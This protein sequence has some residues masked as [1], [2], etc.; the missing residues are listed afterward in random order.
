VSQGTK[1]ACKSSRHGT[2]PGSTDGG[3]FGDFSIWADFGVSFVA[4]DSVTQNPGNLVPA[5]ASS[6]LDAYPVVFG[7]CA[8]WLVVVFLGVAV[9]FVARARRKGAPRVLDF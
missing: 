7:L 6:L 2:S 8:A 3:L 4:M 9:C 1:A 5:P